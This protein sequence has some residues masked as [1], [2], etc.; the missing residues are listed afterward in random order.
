MDAIELSH[1][2]AVLLKEDGREDIASVIEYMLKN[3][4]AAAKIKG[5][6]KRPKHH[7]SFTAEKALGLLLSLKLTKWQYITLRE[8]AIREVAS[9]IY[10]SYYKVQHAKLQCYPPKES[11]TVSDSSAKITLQGLLDITVRR[12]LESFSN[13]VKDKQLTLVSKWGF[14]GASNQSRYK[15]KMDSEQDDSSIFMTSL[16]PLM[17][18]DGDETI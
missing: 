4:E 12:I 13:N 18:T 6:I 1:S 10:P 8:S 17:L 9:D 2:A 11:I 5:F 14:D 15:Q 16:V 7:V 3:P